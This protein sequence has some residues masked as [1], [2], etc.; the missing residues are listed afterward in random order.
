MCLVVVFCLIAQ[1][2]PKPFMYAGLLSRVVNE[3]TSSGPNPK[4]NLKPKSYPKNPKVELG[5]KNVSVIAELFLLY[6]CAPKTKSTSQA[7]IIP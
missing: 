7:R 2:S 3:P 5:V 4:T 6:F 1:C